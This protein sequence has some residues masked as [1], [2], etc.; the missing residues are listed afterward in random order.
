MQR[1]STLSTP[2]P[3]RSL[4]QGWKLGGWLHAAIRRV[5][6]CWHPSMS[7]PFTREC[8]TYRVCLK[9]G[10]RRDFD[11]ES[12]KMFGPFYTED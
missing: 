7:R 11:L 8:R 9:C 4:G 5:F 3:A 6:G 10:M 2:Y 12:W 1:T